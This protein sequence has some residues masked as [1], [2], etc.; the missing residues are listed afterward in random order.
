MKNNKTIFITGGHFTPA[1]SIYKKLEKY[2]KYN[3]YY[4]GV[5]HTILFDKS[6]SQEYI[7]SKKNNINFLSIS[8]GK[9]YRYIGIEAILS[10]IKIPIGFIQSLLYIIKYKPSL[11]I[12]FGSYVSVPIILSAKIFNIKIYSH[13]QTIQ[14]GISDKISSKYSNK[15]FISWKETEQYIKNKNK[16]VYTGNILRDE[17]F[18]NNTN[19][20]DFQN[21][22]PILYITG[23][24]QGSYTINQ[25]IFKSLEPLLTQYNIVHQIGTNTIYKDY[26][27]SLKLK[28]QL[29]N[30]LRNK[31]IPKENIWGNRVGGILNKSDIIIGRSGANTVYEVLALNKK[32]I[33]IPL[34]NGGKNDQKYNSKLAQKYS[35]TIEI[36]DENDLNYDT[37]KSEIE[38]LLSKKNHSNIKIP[39]DAKETISEYIINNI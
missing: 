16:T 20:F 2:N 31:Y 3:L 10:L 5:K 17:V 29:D 15:I 1:I 11:I 23:G 25:I 6:Y 13:I 30:K 14:P 33:F 9:L 39:L 12:A 7:Y 8:T 18:A 28:D 4:I 34:S 37:L 26:D 27:K 19:E 36:I 24:N 21:N 32:A 35:S 22:D 38:K